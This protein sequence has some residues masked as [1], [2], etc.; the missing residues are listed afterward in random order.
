M[1]RSRSLRRRLLGAAITT[2]LLT[3]A[4]ATA[5]AATRWS[6]L[7]TSGQ[8]NISDLVGTARTAEGTLHVAWHRRTADGL[9]DL[10]QTPVSADGRVGTPVPII[11]GWA[12]IEGPSLI[13]S[14]TALNAFY[15]GTRTLVTG[16]PSFGVDSSVGTDGGTIWS[17]APTAVAAGDFA[18]ARDSSVAFGPRGLLTSWYAGAE[19]VVHLG[20]DPGTPNQ[21]GYGLGTGQAIAVSGG[22]ALVAWCTGVQGPNGIFV[23]PVNPATAAP[24][25]AA[26][27]VPGSTSRA[28]D[29][30]REAFCPASTR[31]PLVARQAK[32]FFVATVDGSRRTVIGWS[33]GAARSQRLAGATA[34]KQDVAAAAS[35]GSKAS[36][37]IGWVD[38]SGNIV[39]RR[40][41]ATATVFGA[42]VTVR[43]PRDGTSVGLDLNAQTDR[44]DVVVRVQH[45]DG[46]VG[47]EHAQTFPG[48]TLAARGHRRLSFR[49]LDA[50]DPVAN[51]TVTVAGRSAITGADGRV[52]ITVTRPGR[53]LAHASAPKYLSAS[54]QV[55]VRR[56]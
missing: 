38:E 47:L 25:G 48:L 27:I 15:S 45:G 49:V 4:V 8:L 6:S 29:G 16:D 52:T 30:T 50:G 55:D 51:A 24:A 46:S 33:V 12:S 43:G 56:H 36:V 37:W 42:L 41:N 54:A 26:R 22:S 31:V 17:L 5:G 9:Y 53:Y 19:T 35:P 34:Y 7:K 14:G 44:V 32:G 1:G 10:L 13:A 40:S 21:R 3:G 39:L 23:Q 20:T 11:T 28:P 2:A 18:A